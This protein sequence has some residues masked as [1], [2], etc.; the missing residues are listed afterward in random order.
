MLTR[1]NKFITKHLDLSR[2]KKVAKITGLCQPVAYDAR[3]ES[4]QQ[5]LDGGFADDVVDNA[6]V[7]GREQD[8]VEAEALFVFTDQSLRISPIQF[9]KV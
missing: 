1:K 7:V 6:V 2:K 4:V 5:R 8:L 3:I 9:L